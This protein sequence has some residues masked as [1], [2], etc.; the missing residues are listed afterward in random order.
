MITPEIQELLFENFFR[1]NLINKLTIAQLLVNETPAMVK[2]MNH[3][4]ELLEK[5]YWGE[6]FEVLVSYVNEIEDLSSFFKIY[7]PQGIRRVLLIDVYRDLKEYELF[8]SQC[9]IKS[10]QIGL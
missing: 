7:T 4:K 6:K 9:I 2:E 8:L 5:K 10:I 3:R 1:G